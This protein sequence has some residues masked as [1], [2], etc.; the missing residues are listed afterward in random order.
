MTKLEGTYWAG[1]PCHAN[2]MLQGGEA[3]RHE[4]SNTLFN[5]FKPAA[6]AASGGFAGR[7][8]GLLLRLLASRMNRSR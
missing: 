5:V 1:V 6:K 2:T 3:P 4:G 7:S 8:M